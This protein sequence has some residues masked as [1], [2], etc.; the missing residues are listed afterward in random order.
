[1]NNSF[2][3]L[4]ISSPILK[5]IEDMGFEEPTEVQRRAIPHILNKED[6]IVMSKT[7]S[8]KTAVFGVSVL[9]LTDPDAPGPQGLILTPTR[10]LAVQVDGDIHQLAAH[11][12]HKTTVL[13]GQHSMN[14]EIQ[15]LKKGATIVTGTPGR[16]YDHIQH[17]NLITKNIRFLVLDEADRMLDMGFLEQVERIVKTVPRDRVTLLFS[18]TIPPEIKRICSRHMR[19]PEMIEI[20]SPTLT[21]DTIQQ[22]YYRVNHNEKNTQLNRLLLYEQPE[23]CLIFCNT[24]IATD[25]V[26]TFLTRKGYESQ[27]LHGD[28]PQGRRIKTIEQFKHGEFHILVATDV[29]ARGLQIDNLSLVVNYDVPVEKDSYVHRIGRTGRAG[30][31]GRSITLVTSDDIMGLYEIEEHIGTMIEEGALP[32]D[33]ELNVK[34]A[35]AEKWME[36]N[37]LKERPADIGSEFSSDKR[38][39]PRGKADSGRSHAGG[40]RRQDA[41]EAARQPKHISKQGKPYEAEQEH[42]KGK[43]NEVRDAAQQH[44][45]RDSKAVSYGDRSRSEAARKPDRSAAPMAP[46]RTNAISGRAGV[47]PGRADGAPGRAGVTPGRTDGP[48]KRPAVPLQRPAAPASKQ[49]ARV[50]ANT[51]Q[52]GGKQSGTGR[53][54]HSSAADSGT[55]W[56]SYDQLAKTAPKKS[57]LQKVFG[58]ILGR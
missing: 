34:K 7:G 49:T 36:A 12:K 1:M 16:V 52:Q 25:R 58:K 57:L 3:E 5:A 23:S 31:T 24:R 8:G 56:L 40:Q 14:T 26:Q 10:E 19:D 37:A 51:A 42:R 45:D 15:N 35:Q 50:T 4:G 53:G 41:P 20:E 32:S 47:T 11:L 9:Q 17:G 28:I 39:R 13:Y 46:D 55:K 38:R 29:A 6:L 54:S 2:S 30:N 21:V 33:E 27:A 22:V 18:A 44:G 48:A 43:H